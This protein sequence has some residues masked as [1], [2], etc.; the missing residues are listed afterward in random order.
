MRHRKKR[1][2]LNRL[3][4]QRNAMLVNMAKSL[5]LKGRIKTTLAKAKILRPFVEKLIT[6]AKNNTLHSKRIVAQRLRGWDVIPKLFNEIAPKYSNR[7]GGYTRIIKLGFRNSD[8]AE[9]AIIELVQEE[10][11]EKSE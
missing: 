7:P 11:K 2:K 6:K 1:L 10:L 5:F 4:S 8:S 3:P 9:M